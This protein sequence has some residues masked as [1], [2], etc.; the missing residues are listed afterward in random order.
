M[1]I[2]REPNRSSPLNFR[3][4]NESDA[5]QTHTTDY[6]PLHSRFARLTKQETLQF[7]TQF[8]HLY[9]L[10]LNLPGKIT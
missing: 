3:Q 8:H 9:G 4:P 2:H 6:N 5:D 7:P 10:R 1:N